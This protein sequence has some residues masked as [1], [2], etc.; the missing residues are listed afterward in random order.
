[1]YEEGRASKEKI[2]ALLASRSFKKRK[3]KKMTS[4]YS[5]RRSRSRPELYQT[6]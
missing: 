6:D 3:K 2:M 4:W 5:E 1:M